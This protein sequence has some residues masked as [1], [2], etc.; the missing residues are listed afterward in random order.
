MDIMGWNKELSSIIDGLS[1]R[2]DF[3]DYAGVSDLPASAW[4]PEAAPDAPAKAPPLESGT[5]RAGAT[6]AGQ[7]PVA[8]AVWRLAGEVAFVEGACLSGGG[9][10]P[11]SPAHTAQFE[12]LA[13]WMSGELGIKEIFSAKHGW[14]GEYPA[15]VAGA[16]A[17][18]AELRKNQPRMVV[19]FGPVAAGAF[20]G[21][22]DVKKLRGRVHDIDGLSA[23]ATH[24]PGDILKDKLLK[25]ETHDDLLMALATLKK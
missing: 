8:F 7:A 4:T 13:G 20:F 14:R 18:A 10:R 6:V 24:S 17:V 11:F 9:A 22:P 16:Q 3:L 23:I 25:K 2:L 21:S 5:T 12:K 1:R 15:P 19:I